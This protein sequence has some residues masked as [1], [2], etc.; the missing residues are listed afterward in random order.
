MEKEAME[1]D[2]E[3]VRIIDEKIICLI[4]PVYLKEKNDVLYAAFSPVSSLIDLHPKS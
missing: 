4:D 2:F 1:S 3:T